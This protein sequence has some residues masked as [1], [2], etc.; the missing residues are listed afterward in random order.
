[1]NTILATKYFETWL[2]ELRDNNARMKIIRRI[3]RAEAGNFGDHKNVGGPIWEMRI[4]YGLGYRLY[5]GQT[6][7]TI[8]LLVCGGNKST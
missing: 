7:K 1:M 2:V 6:G 4:D 5:Y 3:E 8:Y